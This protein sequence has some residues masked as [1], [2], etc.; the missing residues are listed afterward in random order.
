LLLSPQQLVSVAKHGNRSAS[1]R[2]GSADVLEA[3]GINLN[4]S[5]EKFQQHW[6]QVG[7]YF[8][9]VLLVGIQH[10]KV[11]IHCARTLTDDI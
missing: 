11:V 8:S 9:F 5:G 6:R 7:Y 10:L 2:V 3:L 1:S 4:A